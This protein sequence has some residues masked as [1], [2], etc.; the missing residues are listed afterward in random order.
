MQD[1]PECSAWVSSKKE[2]IAQLVKHRLVS[3]RI[4]ALDIIRDGMLSKNILEIVSTT[5]HA[6]A[7]AHTAHVEATTATLMSSGAANGDPKAETTGVGNDT[8]VTNLPNNPI[9]EQDKGN[10]TTME[11]T[12]SL[13]HTNSPPFEYRQ[14]ESV[15]HSYNAETYLEPGEIHAEQPPS[16]TEQSHDTTHSETLVWY[17]TEVER[18]YPS[19]LREM[20][21]D[22]IYDIPD[23][24][25]RNRGRALEAALA[26]TIQEIKDGTLQYSPPGNESD[27]TDSENN[28]GPS[29]DDIEKAKWLVCCH[30]LFWA[31]E[32]NDEVVSY[33][34][35]A[36]AN[37]TFRNEHELNGI[38]ASPAGCIRGLRLTKANMLSHLERHHHWI[39]RLA[40]LTLLELD[41]LAQQPND[42]NSEFSAQ[43]SPNKPVNLFNEQEQ[44]AMDIEDGDEDGAEESKEEAVEI[45]DDTKVTVELL[46]DEDMKPAAK[47]TADEE[48]EEMIRSLEKNEEVEDEMDEEA[49][50]GPDQESPDD[51]ANDESDQ[52]SESEASAATRHRDSTQEAP[53]EPT[54]RSKRISRMLRRVDD[55][56][57]HDLSQ[58]EGGE[59]CNEGR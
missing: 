2:Q 19:A 15:D 58:T 54:R 26:T 43:H 38:M 17:R 30:S 56:V 35:F 24:W 25:R 32:T 46:K 10:D 52:S 3:E 57:E 48:Y 37:A 16:N 49:L 47:C 53:A 23:G 14:N 13:P 22:F 34:P 20:L 1:C 21:S 59:D 6:I 8:P 4:R 51:E 36:R 33:C 50:L 18:L 31:H 12:T 29:E 44:V 41:N 28:D 11:E 7:D 42:S 5:E 9:Q 40:H 45:I 55:G 27:A 39:A